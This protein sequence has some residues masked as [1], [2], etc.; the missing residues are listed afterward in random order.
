MCKLFDQYQGEI[1]K[2]CVDNG[3]DFEKAK[4][5]PQCWSKNDIWLQYHDPNKGKNG[6]LDETPSP[7]V[8]KIFVDN[9]KVSIEKTEYTER[10]I[11]R[12]S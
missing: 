5:C 9:G 7:V 3:I 2:L 8:L 10:Y 12:I 1:Q 6:L 4:K 11:G